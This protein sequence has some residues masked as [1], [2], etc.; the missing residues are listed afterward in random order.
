VRPSRLIDGVGDSEE[1][2]ADFFLLVFHA[3]SHTPS[4]QEI[5]RRKSLLLPVPRRNSDELLMLSVFL[6]FY[7]LAKDVLR[8]TCDWKVVVVRCRG[9]HRRRQFPPVL[10]AG[11]EPN[12]RTELEHTAILYSHMDNLFMQHST[13]LV[14][15]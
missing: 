10:K 13:A 12:R 6:V 5:E 7:F 9:A 15:E 1:P 3:L 11:P 14:K 8:G 2:A 4:S